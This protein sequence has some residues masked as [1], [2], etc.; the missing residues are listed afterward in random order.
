MK[1]EKRGEERKAKLW[2]KLKV[3][4]MIIGFYL[5]NGN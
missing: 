4:M 3:W 5:G 2:Q 1:S